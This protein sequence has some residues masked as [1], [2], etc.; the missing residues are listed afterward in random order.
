MC[1]PPFRVTLAFLSLVVPACFLVAAPL[2]GQH[3]ASDQRI[4][5]VRD[6][7][8]QA[9][10]HPDSNQLRHLVSH[11]REA[12]P[13]AAIDRARPFRPQPPSRL[14]GFTFEST[15]IARAGRGAL[16]SA[17]V[18]VVTGTASRSDTA[19]GFVQE[20]FVVE[21][22]R[23]VNAYWRFVP[24]PLARGTT[25]EVA[26]ADT[27]GADFPLSD[28]A[29]ATGET[30]DYD[31]LVGTWEYRFQAREADGSFGSAIFGHWTFEKKPGEGLIEDRF[32]PD[33]ATRPMGASLYTYRTYD[34]ARKVWQILGTSSY[35]GGATTPGLGWSDGPNRYVIQHSPRGWNRFRYTLLEDGHFLWRCDRSLDGGTTWI[36]DFAVLEATRIGR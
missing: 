6:S 28:S 32:R 7:I 17:D 35:R 16:L 11:G 3:S 12:I 24:T 27:L 19:T 14:I 5:A 34:P 15:R 1:R 23:W 33:D 22:G 9:S 13:F 31:P 10:F 30:T 25:L 18:Q 20:L 29:T 4:L 21:G 26:L 8:W 36:R 2:E